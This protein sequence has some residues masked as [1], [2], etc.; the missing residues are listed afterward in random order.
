[1]GNTEIDIIKI[2]ALNLADILIKKIDKLEINS[3]EDKKSIL[4]II[5]ILKKININ[6]YEAYNELIKDEY[7]L[8]LL[9]DHL[10]HST[11][12]SEM[13]EFYQL[14]TS[15][16]F[17]NLIHDLEFKKE[18]LI[19][20]SDKIFKEL[21]QSREL[22]VLPFIIFKNIK[23]LV[24]SKIKDSN[25]SIIYKTSKNVNKSE[26]IELFNLGTY[27]SIL[28][29]YSDFKVFTKNTSSRTIILT[30]DFKP[31]LTGI[32]KRNDRFYPDTHFFKIFP[33]DD[34]KY[35]YG[36]TGLVT[37][38]NIYKQIFKLIKYNITPNILCKVAT[39]EFENFTTDFINSS[40][41]SEKTKEDLIDQ[42]NKINKTYNY[43]HSWERTG[44]IIT[45]PGGKS[46]HDI[47]MKLSKEDRKKV[48]FQII[49]TLYIFD[50]LE[51]SHGD[52]HSANIF[53]QIVPPTTLTYQIKDIDNSLI[54]YKFNTEYL[55]KFY[56]F[57]HS[58][59]G[60]NTPLV[61]NNKKGKVHIEQ[62]LN[63][64]RELYSFFNVNLAET[65]IYN[66][67]LDICILTH[68]GLNMLNKNTK[69]PDY[70]SYM[71]DKD[72]TKFMEDIMPGFN[73]DV[74]IYITYEQLLRYDRVNRDL[75]SEFYGK[76]CDFR[77]K[78]NI[79]IPIL[80]LTW[81]QYSM[82]LKNEYDEFFEKSKKDKKYLFGRPVK[83]IDQVLNNHLWIPDHIILPKLKMLKN[84]YFE[85]LKTDS[86]NKDD[87]IYS[88]HGKI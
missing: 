15:K 55:V 50:I 54:T 21:I 51:I 35:K 58:M 14:L 62:T 9:D 70:A 24:D 18:E 82:L 68:H 26:V 83:S 13:I 86:I 56:D 42:M 76:Y 78:F 38:M 25:H 46:L 29:I 43:K 17:I 87:I 85:S 8:T 60:K 23:E 33:L 20:V 53:V 57:D 27:K 5:E 22:L 10:E 2:N 31:T 41:I 37:E 12:S 81:K 6:F 69:D 47:F 72:Y 84:K 16:N 36:L 77:H 7:L 80:K 4:N 73:S 66:K 11:N 49:Y 61:I 65:N 74:P 67:Q 30:A 3:D 28:D 39:G 63:P 79:D 75:A 45:Q 44:T 40:K 34:D 1:M 64:K 59:I 71:E 52:L 88:I 19:T 32:R 48:M